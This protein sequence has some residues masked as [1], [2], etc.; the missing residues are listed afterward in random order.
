MVASYAGGTT[1]ILQFF[2]NNEEYDA[3]FLKFLG[4]SFKFAFDLIYFRASK[5][6]LWFSLLWSWISIYLH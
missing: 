1:P 3:Y 6:K 4:I 2:Y 5:F